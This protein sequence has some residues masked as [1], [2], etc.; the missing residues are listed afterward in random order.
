MVR[1]T[2]K[3]LT[4]RPA[5]R[6]VGGGTRRTVVGGRNPQHIVPTFLQ[7][8]NTVKL[9]HWKT[10]SFA[11][12]KATDDLY[13]TLGEKI[14]EFV[15]VM[16]GKGEMGGRAKLLNTPVLKLTMISSND[17]FKKQIEIYKKFLLDMSVGNGGVINV[18]ANTDLL[19]IRDEI[20]AALNQFLYLLTLH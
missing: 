9:Y 15:E 1:R 13:G 2:R 4:G 14:E 12:H 10:T 17:A 6:R 5:I 8:L 20:L 16:L 11:T 7:M 19:A 3:I 18:P